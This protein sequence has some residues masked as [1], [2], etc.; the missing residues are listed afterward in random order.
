MTLARLFLL[1]LWPAMLAFSPAFSQKKTGWKTIDNDL[2]SL[3]IPADWAAFPPGER[4]GIHPLERDGG[5]YHLYYISWSAP[6]KGPFLVIRSCYRLDGSDLSVETIVAEEKRTDEPPLGRN[7]VWTELKAPA[8]QKRCRVDKESRWVSVAGS[9]WEELCEFH[10][11][12]KE[13]KRVHHLSLSIK[14]AYWQRHP[15]VRHTVAVVLDS[16]RVKNTD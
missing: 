3:S 12:Q 4:D 5:P 16:F 8:G 13:G 11:F 10:L 14:K 15:E 9:G 2:Y 6:D 1:A 7:A